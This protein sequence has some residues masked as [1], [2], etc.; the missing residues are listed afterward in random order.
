MVPFPPGV[1]MRSSI[2][3][4]L[5][6]SPRPIARLAVS[7]EAPDLQSDGKKA[8]I[9]Y[10]IATFLNIFVRHQEG[11]RLKNAVPAEG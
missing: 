10:L 2:H 3:A 7:A 11:Y 9:C 4:R 8:S 5:S 6:P 1:R